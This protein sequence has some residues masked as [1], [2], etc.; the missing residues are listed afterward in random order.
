MET[1]FYKCLISGAFC[2]M[3]VIFIILTFSGGFHHGSD[4]RVCLQCRGPGFDPWV[5][6]VHWRRKWQP[7]IYPCLENLMD[8]GIWQA[9]VHGVSKSRTELSDLLSLY[10]LRGFRICV[11]VR[12]QGQSTLVLLPGESHGWRRLVGCSPWGC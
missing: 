3:K 5:R 6:K 10:V 8:R 9:T 1:N 2:L 12:R 11:C 4:S 7:T